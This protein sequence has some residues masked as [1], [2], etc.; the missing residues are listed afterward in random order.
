MTNNM[1]AIHLPHEQKVKITCVNQRFSAVV[2]RFS[3]YI[4]TNPKLFARFCSF[5]ICIESAESSR[6]VVHTNTHTVDFLCSMAQI[7]FWSN[8]QSY[9]VPLYVSMA[10][11]CCIDRITTHI[12]AYTPAQIDQTDARLLCIKFASVHRLIFLSLSIRSELLHK[13]WF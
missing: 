1:N 4:W 5:R 6:W 10:F 8:F 12:D 13:V 2:L 3:V 9:Y 7:S 11:V